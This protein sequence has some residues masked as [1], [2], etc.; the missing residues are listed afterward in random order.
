MNGLKIFTI[1]KTIAAISFS[2]STWFNGYDKK[3]Y[4]DTGAL[5]GKCFGKCAVPLL[6]IQARRL[7]W[8][9]EQKNAAINGYYNFTKRRK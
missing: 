6:K 2:N 8:K 5:F 9:K 4:E 1:P 7:S 3:Y